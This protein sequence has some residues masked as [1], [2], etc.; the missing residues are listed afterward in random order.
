M[1]TAMISCKGRREERRRTL[2]QVPVGRYKTIRGV[3]IIEAECESPLPEVTRWGVYRAARMARED[4]AGLLLLGDGLDLADSFESFLKRAIAHGMSTT[5]CVTQNALYP[6][7][8]ERGVRHRAHKSRRG[9][10]G[11]FVRLPMG[12]VQGRVGPYELEAL[13]LPPVVVEAIL[14]GGEDFVRPL[15]PDT[16]GFDLWFRDN[17]HRFGLYAAYP[18][19]VQRRVLDGTHKS[20][21]YELETY[22]E[23]DNGTP[24]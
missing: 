21:S 18:N 11:R 3:G 24:V 13:Y 5:F 16:G 8:F 1:T 14:E 17:V 4:G 6:D 2:F 12:R 19:P 23:E 15:S 10:L 22:F 20:D 9:I 7:D